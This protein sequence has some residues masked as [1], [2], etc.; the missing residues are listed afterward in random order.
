[1]EDRVKVAVD[2]GTLWIGDPSY[3]NRPQVKKF[4]G[5][6]STGKIERDSNVMTSESKELGVLVS[7]GYG[8]GLYDVKFE[9]CVDFSGQP[10]IKSVTI[11]FME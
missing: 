6:I 4:L 2:S 1:M 10:R 9:H 8:D 3:L 5:G 11:R 7:T